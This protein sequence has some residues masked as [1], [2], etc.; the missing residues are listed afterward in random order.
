MEEEYLSSL[1]DSQK[2]A[3]TYCSGPQL[4][5]AGAGSGKTKVLTMKIAYLIKNGFLPDQ[6][7]ALTFTKKAATEMQNRIT[8]LV[9]AQSARRIWMGTFHSLFSRILRQEAKLIGFKSDFTI[10]DQNDSRSLVKSI[11]KEMGLDDKKYKPAAIQSRISNAKN[12][13]FTPGM[14]KNHQELKYYDNQCGIP[15]FFEIYERYW[16]R[17]YQAGVMDFDDLLLYTNILF[18]DHPEVLELYQDHFQYVLV[19][20][21]QDTNRVQ[22]LIVEQ[23]VRKHL[24]LCV[25]GD[26]AQSIYSFR[27]ANIN[28]ILSLQNTIPGLQ[29]FK[30]EQNYRSTKNIVNAANSLIRKNKAQIRKTIFSNKAEGSLIPITATYSDLEEAYSVAMQIATLHH[31]KGYNYADCAI[32]YRTNNQSRTFEEALRKQG[33]AYQIYG[34]LS[35]Y[36]RKE[37][38]DVIA[39]LRLIV[40][41]ADEEAFKRIINYPARGI[42][43]TT[44][45][46]LTE[47]VSQQSVSFFEVCMDPTQY[48]LKFNKGTTAK[49]QAFTELIN[50]YIVLNTQLN[51]Y[52]LTLQLITES[53]IKA[54]LNGDNTIEGVTRQKN[55]EEL[56]SAILQF[57]IEHK[58]SGNSHDSLID[59]LGEVSLSGDVEPSKEQDTESP[60]DRVTLM[61]IHSAKGLEFKNVFIVGVE[62]NLLP[63]EMS[64]NEPG[65]IEEERRLFYVAIT[66]AEE[67]CFLSYAT[68]RFRNGRSDMCRP[69]RFLKDID[70]QYLYNKD[71]NKG[72]SWANNS[73]Q[74]QRST[75]FPTPQKSLSQQPLS[76]QP[77]Y[78]SAFS[79]T[80]QKLPSPKGHTTHSNIT[81]AG[82]PLSIGTIIRHDRFGK[83]HITEIHDA[84][85]NARITVEF[86][87][88]GT[89][90]LLL[91]FAKFKVE[92]E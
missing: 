43:S 60:E 28:N 74:P 81:Y 29:L 12:N 59:F 48:G 78:S 65:G 18:R 47:V 44:V 53:G 62:D 88:L 55:V 72:V 6:I 22:H 32:L 38:K 26:D 41:T 58:E 83:G 11:I 79:G 73:F 56:L 23:L 92:S 36:Q 45:N 39:Y 82:T 77:K 67:N 46:K 91:K 75:Y 84:D 24:R 15:Q 14:Y 49:L 63:S 69:S 34:G 31:Q 90:T 16:N 19:D 50:R 30:L 64:M 80:M 3:V 17:C 5:I 35:F 2:E 89:K 20:E 33:I 57:V 66:R 27:G 70:P 51:A 1:N 76:Q 42:G 25:V 21:Y 9:G 86:D 8:R 87:V 7:I 85:E 37:I 71:T 52:D 68:S 54:D 40:N 61:T 10:Y 4:V 13:L